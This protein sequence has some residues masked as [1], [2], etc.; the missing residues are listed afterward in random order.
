MTDFDPD[1]FKTKFEIAEAAAELYPEHGDSLTYRQIAGETG[2]EVG[3]LFEYFPNKESIFRFYYE[4]IVVRYRLML[5]E[6]EGFEDYLL[7]EKLSNFAFTT[8]DML[9]EKEEFV[10]LTFKTV[11]LW[12]YAKTPFEE[13]VDQLLR[14]F[15][16]GDPRISASSSILMNDYFY[17][18][19]RK[20]Y[21]RL[22]AFWLNDDSDGK[23]LSMELTDKYTA[24]LQEAMYSATLDR[25]LELL[26]F[27]FSNKILTRNIP[28]VKELFSKIEIRG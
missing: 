5:E 12:S 27:M 11:I 18:I 14:D 28:F 4:A 1:L 25:G 23:E 9:Q 15:F 13:A 22:I 16:A 19:L 17:A 2:L 6:I 21:L 10:E 20:K 26:K 7:E 24:F 3:E 8:F